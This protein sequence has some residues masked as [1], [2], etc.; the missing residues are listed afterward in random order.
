[1]KNRGPL[2]LGSLF[3]YSREVSQISLQLRCC[4]RI[5]DAGLVT[6]R[7][8]VRVLGASLPRTAA[9]RARRAAGPHPGHGQTSPGWVNNHPCSSCVEASR[10]PSCALR[11]R[12]GDRFSYGHGLRQALECEARSTTRCP[13]GPFCQS[14]GA[15]STAT[16]S[17]PSATHGPLPSVRYSPLEPWGSSRASRRDLSMPDKSHRLCEVKGGEIATVELARPNATP[18]PHGQQAYGWR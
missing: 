9:R 17:L 18:E 10:H 11:L 16:Y 4:D 3:V 6:T 15:V 5:P 1:M 12:R 8:L 2:S 14:S 13:P 7:S